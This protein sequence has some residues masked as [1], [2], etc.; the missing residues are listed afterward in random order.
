MSK[1]GIVPFAVLGVVMLGLIFVAIRQHD[2]TQEVHKVDSQQS[3]KWQS[4]HEVQ[5]ADWFENDIPDNLEC[6]TLVL[7]MVWQATEDNQISKSNTK[8][9]SLPLTRLKATKQAKGSLLLVA[10]G[11][12]QQSLNATEDFMD[13]TSKSVQ[14]LLAT[15]DV[16]GFAPRGVFPATPEIICDKRDDIDGKT[17][18][19][20]CLANTERDFLA[21]ISTESVVHDID[22]I[23]QAIAVDKINLVGWSYGTKV[24]ARYAEQYPSHLS[25]GVLD[26]V[27]DSTEDMFAVNQGQ[28]LGY[29]KMIKAYFADCDN[30]ANS[31]PFKNDTDYK[32][33]FHEMLHAIDDKALV[34]SQDIPITADRVLALF[35]EQLMWQ[36]LWS[37]GDLL[38]SSLL[39][40]DT[41][42]YDMLSYDYGDRLG[43][44]EDMT[45]INCADSTP[46]MSKQDY[47]TK[48]KAI[49]KLSDY[50]NYNG[51]AN[52]DDEY[53]DACY[54]WQDIALGTDSLQTPTVTTNTPKLLFVAQTGDPATPHQNAVNM[55]RYFDGYLL[56]IEG[57]GHTIVFSGKNHCIDKKA[58]EYLNNP[59]NAID[60]RCQ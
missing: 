17:F 36:E 43:L 56:D 41:A 15:Y 9:I 8:T 12:G 29:D 25:A 6:T 3:I 11:P 48:M 20:G 13:N 2:N 28:A 33:Q 40:E 46:K 54:Y 52:T 32:T 38:L 45:A 49:D 26:G 4:C 57:D 27:V 59:N 50:D 10:G 39:Q 34:D 14:E 18:V 58:L 21:N 24:V 5:F 22:A 37:S 19:Q 30:R 55:A 51:A 31:C 42:I 1:K 47:I 44:N 60:G 16:Y 7:P 35:Y 53:L 23:R